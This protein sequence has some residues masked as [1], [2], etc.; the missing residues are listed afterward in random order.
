MRVQL[1]A[2]GHQTGREIKGVMDM[3][4]R[5]TLKL[6]SYAK[7]VLR[8]EFNILFAESMVLYHIV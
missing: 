8:P 3:D 5:Q 2:V 4:E 7:E 1:W 6:L